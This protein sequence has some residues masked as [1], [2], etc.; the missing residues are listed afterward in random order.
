MAIIAHS[1]DSDYILLDY[2][3]FCVIVNTQNKKDK[4]LCIQL[5]A[6]WKL[7]GGNKASCILLPGCRLFLIRLKYSLT[8]SGEVHNSLGSMICPV[9]LIACRPCSG[10]IQEI[11]GSIVASPA[12]SA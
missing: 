5:W 8:G 9:N 12:S 10:P 6:H 1:V 11:G 4:P 7:A 3:T 2:T